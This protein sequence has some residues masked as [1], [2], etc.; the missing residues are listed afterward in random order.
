MIGAVE[1]GGKVAARVADDLTGKGIVRFLRETVDPMG[2]LLIT[3]EYKAYS[4]A[5]ANYQ[6]AVINHSVAYADGDTHTNTIEGLLGA[7]Q[8]GLVRLPS[9]LHE[10]LDAAVHRGELLEVQPSPRQRRLRLVHAGML[11][12]TWINKLHYGDC[13]TILQNMPLGSVDLIYLDPPFKSNRDY[14]AIYKDETGRALP[15][16]IEAFCDTWTLNAE[17]E[18]AIRLMPVLMRE[19]GLTDEV[20]EFWRLWMNALRKT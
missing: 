18:R 10:A 13:F 12:M 1:R 14:N 17:T 4:A 16:Q 20:A 11:R 2:T 9:P 15:D 3:D 19:A 7:D 5:K 6:H 8:A